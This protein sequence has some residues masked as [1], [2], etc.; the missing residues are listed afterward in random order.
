MIDGIDD[1][2]M[3]SM[4]FGPGLEVRGCMN[5]NLWQEFE[6]EWCYRRKGARRTMH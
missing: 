3:A 4:F 2:P 6:E 1:G 5:D